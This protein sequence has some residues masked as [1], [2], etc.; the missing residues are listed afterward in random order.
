MVVTICLSNFNPYL[1]SYAICQ[2]LL[3]SSEDEEEI[4]KNYKVD[5]QADRQS[6]IRVTYNINS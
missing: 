5:R 6:D 1:P 2:V 3:R 4:K